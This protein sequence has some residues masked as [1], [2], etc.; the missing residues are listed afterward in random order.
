MPTPNDDATPLDGN[1]IKSLLE[2]VSKHLTP[3]PNRHLVVIVGGALLAW[4]GL[5]NTTI[6]VDSIERLG[7]ELETAVA[8]VAQERG[9]EP[10]WLNAEAARF[11][12]AILVLNDCEVL[13]ETDK[14]VVRGAPL[15]AVF[16]MKLLRSQQNDLADIEKILPVAGFMSA[17]EA[18]ESFYEAYPHA[19]EDPELPGLV[20]QLARNGGLDLPL[21]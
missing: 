2:E 13:L 12:P 18:V 8:E 16:A 20:C 19:L 10:D 17:A 15:R 5:R 4:N 11:R 21:E 14:L 3:G 1:A 6:D 7:L 9:L